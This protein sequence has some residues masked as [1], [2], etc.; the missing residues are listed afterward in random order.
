M[1]VGEFHF[2]FALVSH[3]ARKNVCACSRTHK[4]DD[5]TK[6]L[7]ATTIEKETKQAGFGNNNMTPNPKHERHH[8]EDPEEDAACRHHHD[9][10]SHK[11]KKKAAAAAQRQRQ[12]EREEQ[13]RSLESYIPPHLR[14]YVKP[15][16]GDFCYT[17]IF[18]PSLIA[19]LM[20]EGFLPIA[21]RDFLLP[22]LHLQ[23]CVIS[24][25][26]PPAQGSSMT[27]TPVLHTPKSV[28]KRA[29]HF[30]L[31][32]NTAFDAV[33]QGCR[34][35]HGPQCWLYPALVHA[36]Q[37]IH[38]N[39]KTHAITACDCIPW[40]C[41][42][43]ARDNLAAGE[44]GYTVGSIYTSLTG[45]TAES[46]AG[47]VQMAALGALLVQHHY[48]IWDLGMEMG[49]KKSLGSHLMPRQEFVDKVRAV[50]DRDMALP[51]ARRNCRDILDWGRRS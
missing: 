22:K 39:A 47:S 1:V 13:Q 18:H 15:Y 44:L 6:T 50:R 40:K 14:Q 30:D 9:S 35:Q 43:R 19:Q 24:L 2:A 4:D 20:R 28:R 5:L 23:R 42:T 11:K 45:F 16:H 38:N 49:Y 46:G 48:T 27:T 51:P 8:D 25:T 17:P 41:G 10:S 3:S 29:K 31:T 37:T 33:V 36:F 34:N 7:E 26:P 12:Q 21:C 32:L